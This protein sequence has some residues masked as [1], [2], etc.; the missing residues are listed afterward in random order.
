MNRLDAKFSGPELC[1]LGAREAVELLCKGEISPD[2][3]LDAA[4]RRIAEVEPDV[5]ALPTLCEDRARAAAA[6]LSGGGTGHRAWLGGLP[7]AIKT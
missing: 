6:Q 5:N 3:L 4:F 7:L 2:E 1:R